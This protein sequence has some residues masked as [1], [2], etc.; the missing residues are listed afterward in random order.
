MSMSEWM[1]WYSILMPLMG[2]PLG[3][4]LWGR[5]GDSGGA[6]RLLVYAVPV[7]FSYVCPYL[8]SSV[9]GIYRFNTRFGLGKITLLHGFMFGAA[10]GLLAWACVGGSTR[11]GSLCGC[12]RSGFVVGTVL[13]FWNGRFDAW[14]IRVGFAEVYNDAWARGSDA[15]AIAA[16]YAPVYFGTFG[17]CYGVSLELGK[18]LLGQSWFGGGSLAMLAA[19]VPAS[20]VLP[21]LAYGLHSRWRHG[22]WGLGPRPQQS[23]EKGP[24]S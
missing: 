6:Y 17:F 5:D 16:D 21:V 19:A 9:F 7:V 2:L 24:D 22:H 13:A 3:L 12:L 20:T 14:M 1:D 8:G 11:D 18:G 23:Q 10:S 4:F 15:E